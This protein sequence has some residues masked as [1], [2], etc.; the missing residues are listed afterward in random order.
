MVDFCLLNCKPEAPQK[1]REAVE[2]ERLQ[3]ELTDISIEEQVSIRM[4]KEKAKEEQRKAG[5]RSGWRTDMASVY[6]P[7]AKK[8][9]AEGPEGWGAV[10]S[11][12][13]I[14]GAGQMFLKGGPG[15]AFKL[16]GG[17]LMAAGAAIIYFQP[18]KKL[19]GAEAK[20][21]LS[22]LPASPTPYQDEMAQQMLTDLKSGIFKGDGETI[23][24]S[25][26]DQDAKDA[27]QVRLD[28]INKRI[29]N[30]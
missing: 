14:A 20:E 5:E 21:F 29:F 6:T 28:D 15:L 3:H 18:G 2:L 30:K 16:V 26:V 13:S 23:Q 9:N 17:V 24:F 11:G 12:A 8:A 1:S 19:T 7:A 4:A 22:H 25:S 27:I 10:I